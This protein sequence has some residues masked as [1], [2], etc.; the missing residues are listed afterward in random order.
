MISIDL[1]KKGI[2]TMGVGGISIRELL[3]M[4]FLLLVVVFPMIHVLVSKRS[5]GGA[6]TGW[7]LAVFIFSILAYIPFLIVTQKQVDELKSIK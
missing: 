6:K 2:K 1:T 3:I 7:F 5:H 4:F